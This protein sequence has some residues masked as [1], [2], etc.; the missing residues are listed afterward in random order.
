MPVRLSAKSGVRFDKDSLA[1]GRMLGTILL[2]PLDLEVVITSG[3]DSTHSPKSRHYTGEAVD[4]RKRNLENP[5]AF[6]ESL[7]FALGS[8]FTVL[9]EGDHFHVQVRKGHQY[10]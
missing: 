10:S 2:L 1:L 7:Q 8:Q 3:S 9:D 6:K 5:R 4:I